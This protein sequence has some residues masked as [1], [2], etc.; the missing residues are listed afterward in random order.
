MFESQLKLQESK[1]KH[2]IL[3][4]LIFQNQNWN[5]IIHISIQYSWVNIYFVGV[6]LQRQNTETIN[7]SNYWLLS[8]YAIVAI[9]LMIGIVAIQSKNYQS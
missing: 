8:G 7:L 2:H 3:N 6:A 5:Y 9:Q 1:E 4:K